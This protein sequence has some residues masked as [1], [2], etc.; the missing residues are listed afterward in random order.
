VSHEEA[1]HEDLVF[2]ER[3]KSHVLGQSQPKTEPCL[4]YKKEA[5]E[6]VYQLSRSIEPDMAAYDPRHTALGSINEKGDK[7]HNLLQEKE[8]DER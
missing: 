6:F 3:D 1:R 4:E 7:S 8:I 5:V 2:V